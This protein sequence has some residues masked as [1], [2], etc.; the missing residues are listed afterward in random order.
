MLHAISARGPNPLVHSYAVF[1]H[2][3]LFVKVSSIIPPSHFLTF[4]I[5]FSLINTEKV[6]LRAPP[7]N[8]S[9][10]AP[11]YRKSTKNLS[12][13]KIQK[14]LQLILVQQC[15]CMWH[16]V[17]LLFLRR[18]GFL[19]IPS[20]H[21]LVRMIIT[22]RANKAAFLEDRQIRQGEILHMLTEPTLHVNRLFVHELC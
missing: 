20:S 22:A 16:C 14:V 3:L 2:R 18:L 12:M 15:N 19:S 8:H 6:A 4:P 21:V 17:I 7:A 9:F 1:T 10:T 11:L 5:I 13:W